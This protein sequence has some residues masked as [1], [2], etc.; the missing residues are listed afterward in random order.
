MPNLF[1]KAV[2]HLDIAQA[3]ERTAQL[4]FEGMDLTVR[5]GGHV[6]PENVETDLPEA[7]RIATGNGL[8]IP[9]IATQLTDPDD[10]QSETLLATA[11]D[12]GVTHIKLGYTRW[13]FGEYEKLLERMKREGDVWA[14][15]A[16]RYDL[17]IC[18]H[19]HSS[20][21]MTLSAACLREILGDN[22]PDRFGAYIDPAH[23]M[24]EGMWAGWLQALDVLRGRIRMLAI[25]DF[26]LPEGRPPEDH[27][28][29]RPRWV[30]LS[31]GTVQWHRVMPILRDLDFD[32]PISYHGEYTDIDRDRHGELAAQDRAWLEGQGF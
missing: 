26:R 1:S 9:M 11:A 32:G 24:I 17:C 5:P 3:A 21:V 6:L 18:H 16:E 28:G 19:V 4:G 20:P 7:A 14:G 2:Q 22:D 8:A 10:P 13:H 12:C 25:K 31:E 30:P 27:E 15:L 29:V 23:L